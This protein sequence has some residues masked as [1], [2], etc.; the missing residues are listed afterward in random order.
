M[1]FNVEIDAKIQAGS[2]G[3]ADALAENVVKQARGAVG[4]D[5]KVVSADVAVVS[6]RRDTDG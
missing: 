3:A 2:Q 6:E 1:D 4:V 5:A